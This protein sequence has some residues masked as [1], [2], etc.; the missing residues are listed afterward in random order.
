[1]IREAFFHWF[2][3]CISGTSLLG[4]EAVPTLIFP[5][6]DATMA[7]S[8]DA[9]DSSTDAEDATADITIDVACP[10]GASACCGE[11]SCYGD[12]DARC[13]DCAS[14]CRPQ[15]VCC[16][17]NAAVTCHQVGFMCP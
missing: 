16:V 15:Q 2:L 13:S 5:D 6:G 4:C 1:M 12:C 7:G 14:K 8:A 9:G 10:D 17:K 3:A 11:I